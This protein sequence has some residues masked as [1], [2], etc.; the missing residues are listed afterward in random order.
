MA[1]LSALI[2]VAAWAGSQGSQ[3]QAEENELVAARLKRLGKALLLYANDWDEGLPLHAPSDGKSKWYWMD[4]LYPYTRSA[5]DYV[6]P[7]APPEVVSK[8]LLLSPEAGPVGGFGY[9]YQYL[10]NSRHPYAATLTQFSEVARTVAIGDT[11]GAREDD[12]KLA[13]VHALDPPLGSDRGSGVGMYYRGSLWHHRAA[14]A[15][16]RDGK[17]AFVTLDSALKHRTATE[18]DDSNGDGQPDNGW[19]NGHFDAARRR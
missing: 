13:G 17:V 14:P 8:L 4:A 5:A 16:R 2:A 12:G 15:P 11:A 6:A 19:W 9:N 1:G 7:G 10:G 3:S 18:L